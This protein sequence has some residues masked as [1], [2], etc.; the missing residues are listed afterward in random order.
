MVLC[1]FTNHNYVDIELF[2]HCVPLPV[3][4]IMKI[5]NLYNDYP[6]I[7][8]VFKGSFPTE[9]FMHLIHSLSVCITVFLMSFVK[10]VDRYVSSMQYF[11]FCCH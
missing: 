2:Q 9:L 3:A 6:S 10:V 7:I 11:V 8:A 1:N 5:Q 4:K